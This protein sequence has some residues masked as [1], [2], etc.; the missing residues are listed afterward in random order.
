M[1][2]RP[3]ERIRGVAIFIL[4]VVYTNYH[5]KIMAS[6]LSQTVCKKAEKDQKQPQAQKSI[7]GNEIRNSLEKSAARLPFPQP[8]MSL[9]NHASFRNKFGSV[10]QPLN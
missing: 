1:D 7:C 4:V 3:M 2:A 5:I 8:L 6:F 10:S 9:Q